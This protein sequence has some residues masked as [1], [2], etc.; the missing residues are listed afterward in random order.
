MNNSK[1]FIK[2]EEDYKRALEL[3]KILWLKSTDFQSI[4]AKAALMEMIEE[5]ESRGIKN[6]NII[7]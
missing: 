7:N 6:S 5:Y 1:T 3:F 4:K 2:T